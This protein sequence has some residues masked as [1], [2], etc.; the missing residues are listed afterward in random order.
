MGVAVAS[1]GAVVGSST[2]VSAVEA[3]S[4]VA[5]EVPT[6]VLSVAGA[7]VAAVLPQAVTAIVIK[8]RAKNFFIIVIIRLSPDLLHS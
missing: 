4:T 3:I 8:M 5:S 6:M 7:V 1:V 2:T